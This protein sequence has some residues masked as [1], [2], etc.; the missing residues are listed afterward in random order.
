MKPLMD[1]FEYELCLLY[2]AEQKAVRGLGRMAV[3]CGDPDLVQ[4]FKDYQAVSAKRVERLDAIFERIGVL[5]RREPCNGINGLIEEFS[6][7]LEAKTSQEICDV[8]AVESARRVERYLICLYQALIT[9]SVA[10]GR[11]DA[12]EDLA[13][14]L[15]EHSAGG[16]GFKALSINLTEKL[17]VPDPE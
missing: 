10:L 11:D 4:V 17:I 9:L 12:T 14:N 13:S 1:L 5:P 3:K 8:F 6:D 7:F 2:D 16:D 15:A